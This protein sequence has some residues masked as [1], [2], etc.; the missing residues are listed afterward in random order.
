MR[1]TA[2]THG[3]GHSNG[4]S[5]ALEPILEDRPGGVHS[6]QNELYRAGAALRS[7]PTGIAY[8]NFVE[9]DG[10]AVS[11]F[12][13]VPYIKPVQMTPAEFD[14]LRDKVLEENGAIPVELAL[15][16]I[17]DR[18]P[19]PAKKPATPKRRSRDRDAW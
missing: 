5:E 9:P 19:A 7:L 2:R 15:K 14:T 4:F 13:K 12:V 17:A 1:G 16:M 10:R 18:I 8:V 3:T 11:T 6:L